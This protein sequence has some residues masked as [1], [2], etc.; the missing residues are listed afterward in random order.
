M[1]EIYRLA[2]GSMQA[3][4]SKLERVALNLTNS[5]TP[6]YKREVVVTRPFTELVQSTASENL[7]APV[8]MDISSDMRI[9]PLKSTGQSLDVALATDGFFE[10]MGKEGPL[11]T[12]QGNFQ[13]DTQGRLVTSQGYVV[14]GMSGDIR[15]ESSQPTIDAQGKIYERGNLIDQLKIIDF[16]KSEKPI[17]QGEGYFTASGNIKL[18]ESA[19]LQVRQG[20]LE[21]SNVS[22]MHEMVQLMENM[23]HFESMSRAVQ[24]YDE[25][26]GMAIRKLGEA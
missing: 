21:S 8:Q 19:D 15:L 6:A 25:M 23:R 2:L 13:I 24:G 7:A 18:V 14:M 20:Y 22:A 5:A 16:D 4:M 26:I 10:V 3:D 12:R 9:G 1:N 17:R 11:Y